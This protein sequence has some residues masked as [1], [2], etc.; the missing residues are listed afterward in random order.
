RES[1]PAVATDEPPKA[2]R[3]L[4]V[5]T[6]L[7]GNVDPGRSVLHRRQIGTSAAVV[8]GDEVT[9][10]VSVQIVID[11]VE[12]RDAHRLVSE[13]VREAAREPRATLRA[14]VANPH[15]T[16]RDRLVER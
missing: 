10:E 1:P 7:L 5:D 2:F 11:V 4:A 16:L 6:L 14:S 8:A 12:Q 3:G 9:D 13:S 15:A